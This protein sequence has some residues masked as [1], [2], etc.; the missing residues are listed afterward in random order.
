MVTSK[1]LEKRGKKRKGKK[2]AKLFQLPF[3]FV[4]RR[5]VIILFLF[6]IANITTS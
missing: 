2:R 5:I 6:Y 1:S 4:T 3:P